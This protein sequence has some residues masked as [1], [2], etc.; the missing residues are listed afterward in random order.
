M[1]TATVEI[2]SPASGLSKTQSA[3]GNPS[4]TTA[5]RQDQRQTVDDKEKVSLLPSKA[6]WS[7]SSFRIHRS[8]AAAVELPSYMSHYDTRAARSKP[9]LHKIHQ[10]NF[11]IN[12]FRKRKKTLGRDVYLSSWQGKKLLYGRE[13]NG[14]DR[15]PH[16][17]LPHNLQK[18]QFHGLK[19]S[20]LGFFN[21]LNS[22]K[23][24]L[25]HH[26]RGCRFPSSGYCT[27]PLP[28]D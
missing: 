28:K 3:A 9:I 19:I 13:L 7:R 11:S 8:K 25:S 22:H 14:R 23:R 2:V 24:R 18:D 17:D 5:R 21:S 26:K 4:K 20:N 15:I 27:C 6:S 16:G 10:D 1:V 12:G